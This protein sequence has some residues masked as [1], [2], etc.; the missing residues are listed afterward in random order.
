M[1]YNFEFEPNTLYQEL[2]DEV[3][4]LFKDIYSKDNT[5]Y[6]MHCKTVANISESLF[7]LY[8][9][10]EKQTENMFKILAVLSICHDVYEDIP[11]ENLNNFNLILDK[12]EKELSYNF[13]FVLREYLTYNT[14]YMD[15]LDYINNIAFNAD[16]YV[17]LV[18]LAD[19]THNS[20]VSRLHVFTLTKAT[21][22]YIRYQREYSAI[23]KHLFSELS[24]TNECSEFLRKVNGY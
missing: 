10:K 1:Y 2:L 7:N 5:S 3:S 23:F 19:I 8:F 21:E 13:S 18:K 11:F 4:L 9:D 24:S 15:R 16:F 22:K 17:K 14:T 20:L 12:I 6:I